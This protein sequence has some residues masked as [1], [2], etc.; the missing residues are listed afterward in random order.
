M[1]PVSSLGWWTYQTIHLIKLY[2]IKYTY[3]HI[4]IKMTTTTCES[5]IISVCK[6]FYSSSFI[7]MEFSTP[8]NTKTKSSWAL[9][10]AELQHSLRLFLNKR[11]WSNHQ[12]SGL[13]GTP[14]YKIF[15]PELL[16]LNLTKPVDLIPT[17]EEQIKWHN[18]KTKV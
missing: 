13:I 15:S 14:S 5:T 4:H 17:E 10:S 11:P 12:W 9:I 7:N 3:A 18:E 16:S 6:I 2:G 8:N 1:C